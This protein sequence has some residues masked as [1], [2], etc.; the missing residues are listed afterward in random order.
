MTALS[1]IQG[2][3]S[4]LGITSPS[5]VFASTNDQIVQLRNLMNEEGQTLAAGGESFDYGWRALTKE[6]TSP[7]KKSGISA[8][9]S[10]A[11]SLYR[12]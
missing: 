9:L 12:L 7:T 5:V 1:I 8:M 6:K 3:C 10:K 4:Q 2:V 11:R